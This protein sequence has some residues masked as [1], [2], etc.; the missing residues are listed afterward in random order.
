MSK[1][2]LISRYFLLLERNPIQ[3]KVFSACIIFSSAD[4]LS[5]LY[6]VNENKELKKM[7][8]K[9]DFIIKDF[10]WDNKRTIRMAVCNLNIFS[11]L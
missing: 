1:Y 8:I 2:S 5:Q 6:E 3:V 11:I 9:K 7:I 10:E 4:I